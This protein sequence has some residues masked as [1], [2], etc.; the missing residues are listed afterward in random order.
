M[1][2]VEER[3]KAIKG[4]RTIAKALREVNMKVPD[5]KW[6]YV[7]RMSG[8]YIK[9]RFIPKLPGIEEVT[10]DW[11]TWREPVDVLRDGTEWKQDRLLMR[12]RHWSRAARSRT[13][14]ASKERSLKRMV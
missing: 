12:E 1:D 8:V 11:R 9:V 10:R 2:K 7:T 3:G 14:L 6:Q 5:D 13:L 4:L